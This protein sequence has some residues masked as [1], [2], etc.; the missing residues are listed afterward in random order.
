MRGG[1]PPRTSE[2]PAS[3]TVIPSKSFW[4]SPT[5][6][7]STTRPPGRIT[8]REPA[9]NR[10]IQPEPTH[11]ERERGEQLSTAD[12]ARSTTERETGG[13]VRNRAMEENRRA[14]ET[15]IRHMTGGGSSLE[16]ANVRQ[17]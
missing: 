16:G 1:P 6:P 4:S 13:T 14:E 8:V 11:P 9:E 12:L 15:N 2:S 10:P 3:T 17:G 5:A 7:A